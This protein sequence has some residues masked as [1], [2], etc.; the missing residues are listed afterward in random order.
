MSWGGRDGHDG[1][2]ESSAHRLAALL[3]NDAMQT[4]EARRNDSGWQSLLL[5]AQ[6]EDV[7]GAR[8]PWPG[9]LLLLPLLTCA[10]LVAM[11][12]VR[13]Y[14]PAGL[15]F[16]VDGRQPADAYLEA[17]AGR[18]KHIEFSDGSSLELQP[19]GRL[20]VS[21]TRADGASLSLERGELDL[22]I[23]HRAR[24]RW[25][26][27]A[28]PYG[29][30][31]TGTRFH[32]I[33]D[34]ETGELV[35]DL[36]EGTVNVEGPGI[37][38]QITLQAGQ[39]LQAN[40]AGTYSVGSRAQIPPALA[41][42]ALSGSDVLGGSGAAAQVQ[43]GAGTSSGARSGPSAGQERPICDWAALVSSGKFAKTVSEARLLGLDNALAMCPPRGLFA[44][45]DAARY[46]GNFEL[47]RR[48]LMAIRKRSP[49][50]GGKAAFFLGRL[51][52]AGGNYPLAASWYSEAMAGTADLQFVQEAGAGRA[53]LIKGRRSGEST[54]AR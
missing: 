2:D 1:R 15:R 10:V 6:G 14:T 37:T 5:A 35:V 28:G 22:S 49:G 42:V 23:R 20:R 29:V 4:V 9:R 11:V 34:P 13:I 17:D 21:A 25:R 16:T 39:H 48:A 41:A 8:R 36:H 40:R 43:R 54:S 45:A 18:P 50:D 51:A 32:T 30:H 44:L 53:R 52:E 27:E 24:V 47:S 26:V 31:V 46:L 33:W 19:S 7:L 12:L 3:R 38:H